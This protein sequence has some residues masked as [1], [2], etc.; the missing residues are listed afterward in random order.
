MS[1]QDSSSNFGTP[2]QR[3]LDHCESVGLNFRSDKDSKFLFFSIGS[4]VAIYDVTLF[5]TE[6]DELFQIYVRIPVA[7]GEE[8][9]RPLITE[10]VARANHRLSIGSFDLNIDDGVLNYHASH[11]IAGKPLEDDLIRLL[12][13]TALGTVDRYF[14]ALARVVFGGMTPTDAVYLSELDYH[15]AAEDQETG[16][17]KSPA[18]P[19]SKKRTAT[20]KGDAH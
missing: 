16:K 7:V 1:D 11:V 20:Q 6:N 8:N 2:Y 10:F 5:I 18:P 4:K 14:P 13:G 12:L 9:I 17:K 15:I 19:A 3:L